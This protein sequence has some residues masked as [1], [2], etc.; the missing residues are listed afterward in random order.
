MVLIDR[1]RKDETRHGQVA[2]TS[3]QASL[4]LRAPCRVSTDGGCGVTG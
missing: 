3:V 4:G 1:Q 2:L